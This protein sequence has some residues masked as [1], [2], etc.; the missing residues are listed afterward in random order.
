MSYARFSEGDVYIYSDGVALVCC[1]CS[2]RRN[3][4]YETRRA[5]IHHIHEHQKAGHHVPTRCLRRLKEELLREGD[6]VS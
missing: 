5:M 6:R 4:N 1:G 2:L 3:W